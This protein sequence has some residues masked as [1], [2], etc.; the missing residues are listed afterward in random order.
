MR[1]HGND[2]IFPLPKA[3]EERGGNNVDLEDDGKYTFRLKDPILG[4]MAAG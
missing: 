1:K 4:M 2:G 3:I